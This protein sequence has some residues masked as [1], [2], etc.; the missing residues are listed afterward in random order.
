MHQR[1]CRTRGPLSPALFCLGLCVWPALRAL[2][3]E[4]LW[5][6]AGVAPD[7]LQDIQSDGRV[8]F[9]DQ[10]LEPTS[11][12]LLLLGTPFGSLQF[13]A[14]HLQSMSAQH[15]ELLHMLPRLGD[16]QVASLLLL[17]TAAPRAQFALRTLAPGLTRVAL[18]AAVLDTLS[19]VLCAEEPSSLPPAASRVAQ[20]ALRHGGLG[21]RSAALHAPAAFWA[22][23]ADAFTFLSVREAPFLQGL[24]WVVDT[25]NISAGILI[26][27]LLEVT[28]MLV[29][30]GF[31]APVWADLPQHA[32]VLPADDA[33]P[34]V[35]LR[36][37]QRPASRILDDCALAEHRR[38]VGP[39]RTCTVGLTIG[40][41]C[42]QDSHCTLYCS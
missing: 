1:R 15:K 14:N 35:A 25:R 27:D 10:A 4:I 36:G 20:L 19:A 3:Q 26:R 42:S 28:D 6:E 39:C 30:A 38:S 37:S 2:Q 17:Y 9:G 23:W 5:N 24:A 41:I 22:S 12:R 33:E 29:A 32:P 7:S 13:I 21:L 40:P 31:R 11:R 18:D 16:T 34:E 8:W